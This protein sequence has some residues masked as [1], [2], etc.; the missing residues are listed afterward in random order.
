MRFSVNV[1]ALFFGKKIDICDA[2]EQCAKAGVKNIEFWGWWDKDFSRLQKLKET[3]GLEYVGLCPQLTSMVD[4]KEKEGYL[5]HL[6]DSIEAAKKLECKG[7]FVKPGDKTEEQFE[8]QYSNM[9]EILGRAVEMT[10]STDIT[11]LLEPV[12]FMEAPDT[13][14]GYSKLAFQIVEEI[15]DPHLKVLYD[16]YHMQLNEGDIV[17]RAV[18]HLPDIGHIHAAGITDRHELPDGEIDYGYVFGAL[19]QAGYDKLIGLEYFPTKDPLEGI[20]KVIFD[21]QYH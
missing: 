9:K 19:E 8:V 1:D 12:S 21:E 5:R 2:V 6:A 10:A 15:Q 20:K 11:I 7:I 13:F 4:P 16:L 3:Y 18:S 14:L 17:R